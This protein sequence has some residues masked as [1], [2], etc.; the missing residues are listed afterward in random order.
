MYMRLLRG[1]AA[2]V[3]RDVLIPVIHAFV[4]RA[5]RTSV[6]RSVPPSAAAGAAGALVRAALAGSSPRPTLS[7]R[8]CAHERTRLAGWRYSRWERA[9]RP[10][11]AVEQG[12]PV[13]VQ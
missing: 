3:A 5:W 6:E 10:P 13:S 1:G 12:L 2:K 8:N 7:S 11:A 4:P 9:A